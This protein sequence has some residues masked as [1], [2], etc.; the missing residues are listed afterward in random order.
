MDVITVV[1][2][3]LPFLRDLLGLYIIYQLVRNNRIYR[4][5]IKWSNEEDKRFEL[6]EHNFMFNPSKL[7]WYGLKYPKD[8]HY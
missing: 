3:I 7:N 2:S 1:F 8:T 5:R 6:Y 4:I